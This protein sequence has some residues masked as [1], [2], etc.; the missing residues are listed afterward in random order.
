MQVKT[1]SP[2]AWA[3]TERLARQHGLSDAELAGLA[4]GCPQHG[5]AHM[6]FD[7]AGVFC[8]QCEREARLA[9]AQ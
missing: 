4:I 9:G 3:A 6:D 8:H 7:D 2:E 1:M 5:N